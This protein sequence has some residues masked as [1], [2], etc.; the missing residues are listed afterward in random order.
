VAPLSVY[1]RSKADAEAAVAA[2]YPQALIARTSAFFGPWDEANAVHRALAAF[3]AGQR[4]RA[5]G[6][7]RVSPTYVPDLVNV[8]LDLLIDG[9][10]GIW[11]LANDGD[12]SWAD[13]AR[14]AASAMGYSQ[15]L[16]DECLGEELEVAAPR[17]VYSV[18]GSDRGQRLPALDDALAR[19]VAEREHQRRQPSRGTAA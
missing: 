7:Q 15:G 6:D 11:H 19:F 13:L 1:G 12:V 4:W 10:D 17:P 18:L 3:A 14:K 9:A 5:P 16:V 2:A 8:A